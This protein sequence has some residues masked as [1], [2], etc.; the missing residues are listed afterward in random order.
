MG[1]TFLSDSGLIINL[2]CQS[3]TDWLLLLR[4]NWCG[5]GMWRCVSFHWIF[6]GKV[7]FFVTKSCQTQPVGPNFEAKVLSRLWSWIWSRFWNWI[8]LKLKFKNLRASYFWSSDLIFVI[9]FPSVNTVVTVD[10]IKGHCV[11]YCPIKDAKFWPFE[12]T[13]QPCNGQ[14]RSLSNL[15]FC[16]M[17]FRMSSDHGRSSGQT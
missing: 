12:N 17:F 2:P 7:A 8:S 16:L 9:F 5:P 15:I 11:I 6:H 3:L 14:C 10:S 1:V 13:L 4:L